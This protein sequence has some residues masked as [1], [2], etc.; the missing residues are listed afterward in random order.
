MCVMHA[1]IKIAVPDSFISQVVT[2]Y[3]FLGFLLVQ[4]LYEAVAIYEQ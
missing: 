1:H 4:A 3:V 2:I